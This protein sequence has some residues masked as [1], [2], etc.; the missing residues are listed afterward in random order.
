MRPMELKTMPLETAAEV[1]QCLAE[2]EEF[3]SLVAAMQGD[4]V[5]DDVRSMLIEL[6]VELR[7]LAATKGYPYDPQEDKNLTSKTRKMLNCLSPMETKSLLSVF[8]L[9]ER[10]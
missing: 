4:L 3:E 1:L 2:R 10:K 8:G 7:K 9:I 5:R 6:A